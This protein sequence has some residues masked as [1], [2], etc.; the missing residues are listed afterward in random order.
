M[1]DV[2]INEFD[3]V[4]DKLNELISFGYINNDL[5]VSVK[6]IYDESYLTLTY[7]GEYINEND[8][9]FNKI[10]SDMMYIAYNDDEEDKDFFH[11]FINFKESIFSILMLN[12]SINWDVIN[13]IF[14]NMYSRIFEKVEI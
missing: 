7:D 6:N 12:Q 4:S 9:N 11:T 8:L 1:I 14:D 2:N 3:I 10:F 5:L 13:G